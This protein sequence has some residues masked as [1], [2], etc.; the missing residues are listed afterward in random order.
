VKEF[1][2]LEKPLKGWFVIESELNQ[3][4]LTVKEGKASSGQQVVNSSPK[5]DKQGQLWMWKE[6][7][8]L[9]KLDRS[10]VL[11]GTFG[12]VSIK[13]KKHG[14]IYQKWRKSGGF[15]VNA[16]HCEV[17]DVANGKKD[18][19]ALVTIWSVHN[20]SHQKWSTKL[21]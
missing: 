7:Y 13:K 19:D 8:L 14:N 20:N 11:D 6:G 9:S 2:T 5:T 18:N 15:L 4:Y 16:G 21:V 10:L 12:K 1:E 17:L 3:K